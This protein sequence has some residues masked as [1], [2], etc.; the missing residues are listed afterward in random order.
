MNPGGLL[1][2]LKLNE[3]GIL[4][5]G[6]TLF[7]RH[8]FPAE[9]IARAAWLYPRFLLSPRMVEDLLAAREIIVTH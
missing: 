3:A 1:W 7:R 4:I 5:C 8:R 9:V 2:H 6:N